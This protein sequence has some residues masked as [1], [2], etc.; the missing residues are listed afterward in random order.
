MEGLVPRFLT[1]GLQTDQFRQVDV[2]AHC[3]GLVRNPSFPDAVN[4]ALD[5]AIVICL[6]VEWFERGSG[7]ITEL[8]V[9]V[10][11]SPRDSPNDPFRPLWKMAVHHAR[12]IEHAHMVNGK[13]CEAHP[14]NFDFG[15]TRFVTLE[16]GR[17][18]L[19]HNFITYG[20]ELNLRPIVLIGHA[21]ENDIEAMKEHLEVDLASL[22]VIL[23]ALDTQF[24][25]QE[26]NIGVTNKKISLKNLLGHFGIYREHLHNAGNDAGMTIMAAWLMAHE[27]VTPGKYVAD[28]HGT[29]VRGQI[30][31]L[32]SKIAIGSVRLNSETCGGPEFGITTFCTRCDSALHLASECT[33][34]VWCTKCAEH[35][36]YAN[37]AGTHKTE[38]CGLVIVPCEYCSQCRE[39]K[40]WKR[41]D[42][43]TTANC[44]HLH[45]RRYNLHWH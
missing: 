1:A 36:R 9:G 41:A 16:E 25:A 5:N 3:I 37:S 6:D 18:L 29:L 33:T 35:P 4:E 32:H 34:D 2:L 14:E 27:A 43:H 26:L 11:A 22:G 28:R 20:E 12:M 7:S 44:R 21:V 38:K 8:G 10:V 39:P 45:S 24:M 31:Q 23:V 40:K 13:K 15:A 42:T 17:Q 30:N 19:L